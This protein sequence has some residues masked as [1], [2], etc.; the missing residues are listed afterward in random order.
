V[1]REELHRPYAE[2]LA[3]NGILP[4]AAVWKDATTNAFL[5]SA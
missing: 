3:V 2:W 1:Q 5:E 4:D